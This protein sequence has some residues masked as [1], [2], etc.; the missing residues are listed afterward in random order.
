MQKVYWE[1]FWMTGKV[2]DYLC[3]KGMAICET[4]LNR[5]GKEDT[6][7]SDNSYRDGASGNTNS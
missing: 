6:C 7:E 2:E 4:I 5:Y 3:Y 1:Q